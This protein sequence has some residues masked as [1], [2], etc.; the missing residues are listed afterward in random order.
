VLPKEACLAEYKA[1]VESEKARVGSNIKRLL[2]SQELDFRELYLIPTLFYNYTTL[3][4]D[5]Y[6]VTV[7]NIEDAE[8]RL[9]ALIAEHNVRTAELK[10]YERMAYTEQRRYVLTTLLYAPVDPKVA[11]LPVSHVKQLEVANTSAME[12]RKA[13]AEA[14]IKRLKDKITSVK[15]N[16]PLEKKA[17]LANEK[18]AKSAEILYSRA[19]KQLILAEQRAEKQRILAEQRAE[20]LR[21]RAERNR[22]L[23]EKA[24]RLAYERAQRRD[25]DRKREERIAAEKAEKRRLAQQREA[26]KAEYKRL[27]AQQ[28]EAKRLKQQKE[29]KKA[30]KELQKE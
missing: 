25:L 10:R 2:R 19:E 21:L 7:D 1:F 5:D 15:N 18:S 17:A 29:L 24:E 27:V 28:I 20:G 3:V 22:I 8:E 16:L 13:A 11:A 12:A 14:C 23:A 30:L 6:E 4:P 26:T 9:T